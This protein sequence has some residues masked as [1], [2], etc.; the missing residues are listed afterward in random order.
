MELMHQ[1]RGAAS[2]KARLRKSLDEIRNEKQNQS[3]DEEEVN[4]TRKSYSRRTN[5]E[6]CQATDKDIIVATDSK[7]IFHEGKRFYGS[8]SKKVLTDGKTYTYIPANQHAMIS[9]VSR[10]EKRSRGLVLDDVITRLSCGTV[11]EVDKKAE[12]AMLMTS[13]LKYRRDEAL[14]WAKEANLTQQ[15]LT[16]IQAVSLQA[17]LRLSNNKVRNMRTCLN[18]LNMN[19]WTSEKKMKKAKDP[20]VSHVQPNAVETGMVMMLKKRT[21]EE[22]SSCPSIRVKDLIKYIHDIIA[23]DSDDLLPLYRIPLRRILIST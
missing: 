22:L 4:R 15:V 9:Q 17:I 2:G 8:Y 16:P 6:I 14:V 5:T 13:F 10:E 1:Y 23:K 18:S 20:L 19:V 3:D 12:R 7:G 21:D 11:S